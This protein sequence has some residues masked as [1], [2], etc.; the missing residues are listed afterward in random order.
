MVVTLS[1]SCITARLR[2]ALMRVPFTNTVQAPQCP[3][4]QPFLVP[5]KRRCSRRASRRVVRVSSV[6]ERRTPLTSIETVIFGTRPLGDC[7]EDKRVGA[8]VI[9]VVA[10]TLDAGGFVLPLMVW[11]P[12]VLTGDRWMS[13]AP[14]LGK[15][16]N[17]R[18]QRPLPIAARYRTP[19][20]VSVNQSPHQCR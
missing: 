18:E 3:W 19:E 16:S 13:A 1:P 12:R 2:Q 9:G 4:S 15:P 8:P 10:G 14:A 20:P 6:S 11:S 5:V 7:W 17:Y